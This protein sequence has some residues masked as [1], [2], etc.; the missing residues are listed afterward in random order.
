[1]LVN[2]QNNIDGDES[3]CSE[4]QSMLHSRW[5]NKKSEKL[6][7]AL[8]HTRKIAF[9]KHIAPM[10]YFPSYRIVADAIMKLMTGNE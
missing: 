3:K 2:I 6:A 8:M 1:M 9:I 7:S 4:Y 10:I 5:I